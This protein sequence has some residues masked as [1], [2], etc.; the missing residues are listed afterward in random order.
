MKNKMKDSDLPN[1]TQDDDKYEE[2]SELLSKTK[3]IT[4]KRINDVKTKPGGGFS[5]T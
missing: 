2:T 4:L 1:Q 5:N 3:S